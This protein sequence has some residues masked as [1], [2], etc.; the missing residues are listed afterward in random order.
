MVF[1]AINN[2]T[3]IFAYLIG[4]FNQSL[5]NLSIELKISHFGNNFGNNFNNCIDIQE[6]F[7]KKFVVCII[8]SLSII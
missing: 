4:T 7:S 3:F 5:N 1:T 8:N 2:K 6:T